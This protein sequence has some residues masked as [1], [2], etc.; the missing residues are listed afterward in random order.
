[1][2]AVCKTI[3]VGIPSVSF[4]FLRGGCCSILLSFDGVTI[5]AIFL[6]TIVIVGRGRRWLQVP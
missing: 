4:A 5:F 2:L 6:S 3:L 1:M